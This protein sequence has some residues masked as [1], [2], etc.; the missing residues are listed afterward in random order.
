MRSSGYCTDAKYFDSSRPPGPALLVQHGHPRDELGLLAVD[1]D[2]RPARRHQAHQVQLLHALGQDA[3]GVPDRHP[4][5][6]GGQVVLQE[7]QGD[8]ESRR[9]YDRVVV[10]E[11]AVGEVHRA[12]VDPLGSRTNLDAAVVNPV[13]RDGEVIFST[14][15]GRA[16]PRN[17]LRD[18]TISVLVVDRDNGY[19]TSTIHG[20]ARLETDDAVEL[21]DELSH[22]YTGQ[23]WTETQTRPRIVVVVTPTRTTD[24]GE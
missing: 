16:K 24:H 3:A 8:V 4:I 23:P 21:I 1:R 7:W 6:P 17:L 5:A 12:A 13:Q 10:P 15:E 18:P 2:L 19:R 14:V 9:P 11:A 20:R 22:K